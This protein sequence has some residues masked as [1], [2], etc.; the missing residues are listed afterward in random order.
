MEKSQI[1]KLFLCLISIVF[2]VSCDDDTVS[3]GSNVLPDMNKVTTSMITYAVNSRSV[4]ADSVLGNTNYCYLGSITRF[5]FPSE[6]GRR[7]AQLI[8]CV[9]WF[10]NCPTEEFRFTHLTGSPGFTNRRRNRPF[11]EFAD[12]VGGTLRSATVSELGVGNV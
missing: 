5:A 4:K 2:A 6:R 7:A 11:Q 1:F 8:P 9:P 3:V 10:S 12:T